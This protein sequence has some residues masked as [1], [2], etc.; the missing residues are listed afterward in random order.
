MFENYSI[1]QLRHM[2]AQYRDSHT[3]RGYSRMK[4]SVLI[5]ELEKR[6]VVR[7]GKLE[8][9]SAHAPAN[10]EPLKKRITP[11]LVNTTSK[12]A[13]SLFTSHSTHS[14]ATRRALEKAD[15]LEKYY[16]NGNHVDEYPHLAF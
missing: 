16:S 6:F 5:A 13:N 11:V 7:D 10:R 3:L 1:K 4:K 12:P 14:N 8:P 9:K 2:L 15:E